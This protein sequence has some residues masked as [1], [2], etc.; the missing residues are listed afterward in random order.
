MSINYVDVNSLGHASM[1]KP[2]GHTPDP[3]EIPLKPPEIKQA[4]VLFIDDDPNMLFLG[5]HSMRKGGFDVTACTDVEGLEK[6]RSRDFDDFD[7]VVTDLN[8]PT[9]NGVEIL[10]AVAGR[11]PVVVFTDSFEDNPDRVAN[12]GSQKITQNG[13]KEL[14]AAEVIGKESDKLPAAVRRALQK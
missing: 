7:V 14:G 3:S 13:L 1:Q 9:A 4:R 8:M 10:K 12:L 11:K 5:S 2:P 6:I